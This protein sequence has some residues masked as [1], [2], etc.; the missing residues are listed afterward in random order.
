MQTLR[1]YREIAE[2]AT[3]AM[4]T[5]DRVNQDPPLAMLTGAVEERFAN[6]PPNA[7][8]LVDAMRK[9]MR[10]RAR[11]RD[12]I[13]VNPLYRQAEEPLRS[14]SPQGW[15]NLAQKIREAA[16]D[17]QFAGANYSSTRA[18][19]AALAKKV[20]QKAEKRQAQ[21][22]DG[23]RTRDNLIANPVFDAARVAVRLHDKL[24]GRARDA[25]RSFRDDMEDV[26]S[27]M[28]DDV[29]GM[30]RRGTPR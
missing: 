24:G 7:K 22:K 3:D 17:E 5:R 30:D 29:A 26:P 11:T 28:P 23:M 19:L 16:Q 18:E 20:D 25:L 10:D 9:D 8:A 12:A 6:M 14:N 1:Q 27:R 4:R 15:R 21:L 13:S 2:S